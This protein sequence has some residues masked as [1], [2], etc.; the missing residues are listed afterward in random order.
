MNQH[1][2]RT[3]PPSTPSAADP[4]VPAAVPAARRAGRRR[5]GIGR[6]ILRGT[7][8][9][10]AAV[11]LIGGTIALRMR[12]DI[13]DTRRHMQGEDITDAGADGSARYKGLTWRLVRAPA[14]PDEPIAGQGAPKGWAQ[15][16]AL[17]EITGDTDRIDR[18][19]RESSYG[20]KGKMT[21][22]DF[23]DT[24]DRRWGA[25]PGFEAYRRVDVERQPVVLRVWG[26]IPEQVADDIDVVL[27]VSPKA[28]ILE[29]GES[30]PWTHSLRMRG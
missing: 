19:V 14:E 26:D 18:I 4:L 7:A 20:D 30:P 6:R 25:V 22:V 27:T 3:A 15:R 23:A 17:I 16:E 12:S 13:A 5:R 10:L 29:P 24:D 2:P 1:E 8:L 11:L 28:P 9:V 21:T